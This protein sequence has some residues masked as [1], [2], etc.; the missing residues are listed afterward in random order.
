M[1]WQQLVTALIMDFILI[2]KNFILILLW[3]RSGSRNDS[4]DSIL[5]NE[6]IWLKV[7]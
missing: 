7:F 5:M 2:S 4:D 1:I 3:Y 6:E